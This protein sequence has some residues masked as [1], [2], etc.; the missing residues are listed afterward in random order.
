[1]SGSEDLGE[2]LLFGQS[3]DPECK[4]MTTSLLHGIS[5]NDLEQLL[6]C[7]N[8]KPILF[9]NYLNLINLVQQIKLDCASAL[10]SFF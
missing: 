1:M 8:F 7:D 2:K 10:P 4:T 3:D 6:T 9:T 5:F